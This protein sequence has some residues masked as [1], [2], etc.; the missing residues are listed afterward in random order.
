MRSPSTVPALS[1]NSSR[2]A[3]PARWNFGH[4][5]SLRSMRGSGYLLALVALLVACQ[6]PGATT[7]PRASLRPPVAFETLCGLT[8]A[9]ME[10]MRGA[11]IRQWLEGPGHDNVSTFQLTPEPG[12]DR[13]VTQYQWAQAGARRGLAVVVDDRLVRVALLDVEDGPTL[14]DVVR[15]FGPPISIYASS[16]RY[17]QVLY[18][19]SLEYPAQGVSVGSD[20][21]RSSEELA[22]E[23]GLALEL[24]PDL[25]VRRIDCFQPATSMETVLREAFRFTPEQIAATLRSTEPWPGFGARVRLEGRYP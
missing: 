12:E 17:E 2:G 6:P 7:A 10:A 14:G 8:L 18:Y 22:S 11:E 3:R 24:A 9:Q 23:E 5:F 20:G 13:G 16:T 21:L 19:L 25:P 4:R 1:R 15:A